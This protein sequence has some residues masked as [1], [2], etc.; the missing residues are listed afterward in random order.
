MAKNLVILHHV[1]P[2]ELRLLSL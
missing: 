2:N 1:K